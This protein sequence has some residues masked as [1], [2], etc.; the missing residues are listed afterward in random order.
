M[1]EAEV[2]VAEIGSTV[3]KVHA[4]AGLDTAEP[5]RLGRGTAPTTVAEGDV[6]RGLRAA[7]ADLERSLGHPLSWRRMLAASSAAGGLRMT[8]HGLV[9]DMTVRAAR[10]AALGAGALLDLV[11]V[12]RMGPDE[13]RRLRESRPGIILLAGGVEN[14]DREVAVHNAGVIAAAGHRAP[15]IYAGNQ[16]ARGE[17]LARLEA[18]GIPVRVVDNVYPRLDE[19]NVEPA[20]RAIQ[21]VFEEHIVEAP[22]MARVR[23]MVSGAIR[24]TPGAV[25]TATRALREVLGDLVVID[26]G[27]ATTDV[28]S[29]TDGSEELRRILVHPEPEAKRT[30]EGDLGVYVNAANVV[31]A[32]GTEVVAAYYHAVRALAGRDGPEHPGPRTSPAEEIVELLGRLVPLPPGAMP[33]ALA[34]LVEALAWLA[35]EIALR[36]HAGRVRHLYG[37]TGRVTVAEGKDLTEV[38]WVVGTGGPLTQFAHG[39]RILGDLVDPAPATGCFPGGRRPRLTVGGDADLGRVPGL[40]LVPGRGARPLIDREYV[41]AALGVLHSEYPEAAR[42]LLVGSLGPVE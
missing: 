14:G 38:E 10:E 36:R 11:T 39:S 27:G 9:H 28:H 21:E 13:A 35:A 5:R 30:V 8:V 2:L 12:G 1:P 22:G 25:M 4:F 24:P 34:A 42:Q 3:T 20:R 23:E 33:P 19:L 18:A 37:P 7:V 41:L 31:A 32:A 40:P 29:V 15:V 6:T 17:V 26:V 16:A